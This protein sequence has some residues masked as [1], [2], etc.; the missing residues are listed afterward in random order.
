EKA[1]LDKQLGSTIIGNPINVKKRLQSF[2]DDTKADEI[3][4]ST[5]VYDHKARLHS[6]QLL[7]EIIGL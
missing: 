1:V 2:L 6:H 5:M 4:V 3:M 7:A